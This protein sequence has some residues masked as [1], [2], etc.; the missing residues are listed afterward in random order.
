MCSGV[1]TTCAHT[2]TR[3]IGLCGGYIPFPL[4]RL[5]PVGTSALDLAWAQLVGTAD[6]TPR[7]RRPPRPP[8]SPE[9]MLLACEGA[10]RLYSVA[11]LLA[12]DR[13]TVCKLDCK[14]PLRCAQVRSCHTRFAAFELPVLDSE[15]CFVSLIGDPMEA[16]YPSLESLPGASFVDVQ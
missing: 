13:T 11:N 10:L 6:L 2:C 4:D 15:F 12:K 8:P 3:L 9:Y 7:P 14:E 16:A 1:P 5:V